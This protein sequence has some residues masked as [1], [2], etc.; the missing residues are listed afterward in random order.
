MKTQTWFSSLFSRAFS[1]K[2]LNHFSRIKL[3]TGFADNIVR[4]LRCN[5]R[6]PEKDEIKFQAA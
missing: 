1:D 3:F 5:T 4:V 2:A 6:Q